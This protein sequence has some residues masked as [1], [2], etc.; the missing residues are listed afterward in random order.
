MKKLCIIHA[1]MPKTGS[2][3]IQN[4][5]F[6]LNLNPDYKYSSLG[7]PNHSGFI[8]SLFSDNPKEYHYNLAHKRSDLQVKH[9]NNETQCKLTQEFTHGDYSKVI[10]SGED[11][12]HLSCDELRKMY[13]FISPFFE[14]IVVVAY[15]RP[16]RSFMS[17]AFQQIVK[18]HSLSSF[19]LDDI[20][21]PYENFKNFDHVF[22]RENVWLRLF[23]PSFLKNSDIVTDFL[24]YIGLLDSNSKINLTRENQSL[25]LEATS[26]LYLYN[27]VFKN[28]S[29]KNID[30][31]AYIN[32]TELVQN[33]GNTSFL[34]NRRLVKKFLN[35]KKSEIDYISN[36]MSLNI[37]QYDSTQEGGVSSH[38]E[39]IQIALKQLPIFEKYFKNLSEKKI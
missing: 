6:E 26:L 16:P 2:T 35:T 27:F 14:R 39:I 24:N 10:L 9:F 13:N 32:L 38:D 1:G 5:L 34:L 7:Q 15:V 3:S 30:N 18:M 31:V 8:Y 4:F 20:Y 28:T 29:L 37:L 12:F 22:G 25:S 33:Y 36:R 11:V 21:H 23:H 17:S 19:S